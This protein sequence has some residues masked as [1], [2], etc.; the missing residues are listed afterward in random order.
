MLAAL[1]RAN[2]IPAGF[3]YQRL[4][5]NDDGE[6]YSLHGFNAVYFP[7]IGWYR[8]DARGNR[9]GVNAQFTPPE[10]Q[11]AFRIQFPEEADF[12]NILSEPLSVV[13]QA[14]RAHSTW[15]DLLSNLP[16]VPLNSLEKYNLIVK[17][18]A[19]QNKVVV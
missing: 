17:A 4:S 3:C 5:V 10:E 7:K 16:D 18:N 8:V 14:L 9:K 15:D 2:G 12:Q 6:P 11:L 1:L 19:T 13:V